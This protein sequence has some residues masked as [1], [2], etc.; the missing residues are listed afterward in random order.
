M[1]THSSTLAWKTPRTEKPGRLQS[2]GSQRVR[3][4][5][6]TSLIRLLKTSGWGTLHLPS[7]VCVKSFLCPSYTL[8]KPCYTKALEWSSLVPDSKA[9]SSF[10]GDHESDIVH[11]KLT[12]PRYLAWEIK[13]FVIYEYERP[14]KSRFRENS[15]YFCLWPS[16]L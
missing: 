16:Y 10:F 13:I 3:H 6:A 8:I 1:A 15:Q 4:D 5:W 12:F 14:S 7:D 9:K 2:M 11:H